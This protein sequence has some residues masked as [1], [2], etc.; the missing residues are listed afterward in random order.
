MAETDTG[1][2]EEVQGGVRST[3]RVGSED[4][5]VR[6]EVFSI[7]YDWRRSNRAPEGEWVASVTVHHYLPD[8]RHDW[9][10]FWSHATRKEY[11]E[12]TQTGRGESREAA[13]G[14]AL[15]KAMGVVA[16]MKVAERRR[17]TR[18][19]AGVADLGVTAR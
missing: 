3:A 14:D 13:M 17:W 12:Q 15:V 1:E 6:T 16:A 8:P 10:A 18:V 7:R 19:A 2:G 9:K 4:V 11:V 5:E